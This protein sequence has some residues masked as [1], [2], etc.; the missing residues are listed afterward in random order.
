MDYETVG[1]I[2]SLIVT[3]VVLIILGA[4]RLARPGSRVVLGVSLR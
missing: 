2:G 1:L 3:G 4:S